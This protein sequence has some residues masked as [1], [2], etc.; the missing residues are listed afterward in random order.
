MGALAQSHPSKFGSS[1]LDSSSGGSTD[2]PS[3]DQGAAS[4]LPR[5]VTSPITVVF[6]SFCATA[7]FPSEASLLLPG[8]LTEAGKRI[9]PQHRFLWQRE[10]QTRSW[11]PG[12]AL[13][14]KD[15]ASVSSEGSSPVSIRRYSRSAHSA[16][17]PNRRRA[18][19]RRSRMT[20]SAS[21]TGP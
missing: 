21:A 17:V 3:L 11:Y 13:S 7:A 14:R 12:R 2:R 5:A 1:H 8:R 10:N 6:A 9:Q 4:V 16:M 15:A 18:R 19:G 20:A